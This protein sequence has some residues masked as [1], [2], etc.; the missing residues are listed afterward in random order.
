VISVYFL[1]WKKNSNRFRWL[2]R[3]SFWVP[4]RGFE[5]IDQEELNGVFQAWVRRVQEVS[6]S[7]RDYVRWQLIFIY[8]GYVKFHQTW[9]AYVLVDQM[10]TLS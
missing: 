2:T 4:A 8:I 7:N 9:L 5:C 10:I 3:I 1:Q 6:Q